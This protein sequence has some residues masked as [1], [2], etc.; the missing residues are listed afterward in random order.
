[1]TDSKYVCLG[2]VDHLDRWEQNHFYNTKSKPLA[3]AELWRSISENNKIVKPRV[4]HQSS[5][6]VQ[7]TSAAVGNKEI[8]QYIRIGAVTNK[9]ERNLLQELHD[10][11]NHPST[12]YVAEYCQQMGLHC[13]VLLQF[14][15]TVL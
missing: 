9:S 11:L 3:Q 5:H 8:A 7:K 4:L 6:T 15:N 10:K 13:S 1:M 14:T 2:L 12:T